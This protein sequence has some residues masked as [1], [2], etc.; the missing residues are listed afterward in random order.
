MI[1]NLSMP[2]GPSVAEVTLALMVSVA[3]AVCVYY[4]K[5]CF[6]WRYAPLQRTSYLSH[7]DAHI[8]SN[9]IL[10]SPLPPAGRARWIC[11]SLMSIRIWH[12]RYCCSQTSYELSARGERRRVECGA[13]ASTYIPE[14]ISSS[15]ISILWLHVVTIQPL[16]LN[17]FETAAAPPGH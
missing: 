13:R 6:L 3:P 7:S 17:A 8:R 5:Q 1:L 16:W 11:F 4:N 14:N 10:P 9:K 15:F 2:T 12:N